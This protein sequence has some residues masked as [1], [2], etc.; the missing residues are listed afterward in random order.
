MWAL[1]RSWADCFFAGN[2]MTSFFLTRKPSKKGITSCS[3]L[4]LLSSWLQNEL[5]GAKEGIHDIV[6]SFPEG[7]RRKYST[8]TIKSQC[9]HSFMSGLI[10][11]LTIIASLTFARK[12]ELSFL[13]SGQTSNYQFKV[14]D[15]RC[16]TPLRVGKFSF[17]GRCF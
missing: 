7:S 6:D 12:S 9:A 1:F 15:S 17:S 3:V 5:N 8:V 14:R 4:T 11:R 13:A 10:R 16:A 2:T